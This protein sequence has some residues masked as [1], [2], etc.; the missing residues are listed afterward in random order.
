MAP[1]L[2]GKF[3]DFFAQQELSLTFR[4]AGGARDF[5]LQTFNIQQWDFFFLFAFIIGLYSLHRL[6]AVKEIGEVEENI[7]VNE[8]V[9]EARRLTRSLS[10]IGGLRQLTQFP[11][12]VIRK[13]SGK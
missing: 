6:S 9:A 12:A 11:F 10:P 5:S 2:G 1:I 7:V 13:I 8:L 3:I 4:W